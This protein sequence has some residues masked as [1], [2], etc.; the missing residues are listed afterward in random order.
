MFKHKRKPLDSLAGFEGGIADLDQIAIT[1]LRWDQGGEFTASVF[2]HFCKAG[3]VHQ[4]L[5]AQY[6]RHQNGTAECPW[7][8]LMHKPG[9]MVDDDHFPRSQG[10]A[11][12][13]TVVCP[14]NRLPTGVNSGE[15]PYKLCHGKISP[16]AVP[17]QDY[18]H[19]STRAQ[20][21]A[22]QKG[23][24]TVDSDFGARQAHQLLQK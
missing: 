16:L 17:A 9:G 4:E 6:S 8:S 24:R 12:F 13:D 7:P 15:T 11:V 2:Q 5:P 21:T 20:G 10:L 14:M 23:E 1:A 18:S 22:G 19:Q 3:G